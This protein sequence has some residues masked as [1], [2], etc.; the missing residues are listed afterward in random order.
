MKKAEVNTS[1][2]SSKPGI[3]LEILLKKKKP[4]KYTP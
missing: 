4:S 3:D 2:M 1:F